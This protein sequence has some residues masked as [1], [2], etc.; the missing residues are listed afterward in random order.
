MLIAVAVIAIGIYFWRL[1]AIVLGPFSL[2]YAT[3]PEFRDSA[4]FARAMEESRQRAEIHQKIA[5]WL[6][7]GITI[8]AA[9]VILK[10]MRTRGK[11]AGRL[12]ASDS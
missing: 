9:V 8:V 5:G 4:E 2:F 6:C 1:P 3:K 11:S 12:K 10:W 7:F